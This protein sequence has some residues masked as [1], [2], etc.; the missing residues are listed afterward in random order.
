MCGGVWL[1]MQQCS[2]VG[3][4]IILSQDVEISTRFCILG[5]NV[6]VDGWSAVLNHPRILLAA[7]RFVYFRSSR[8]LD[9]SP[10]IDRASVGSNIAFCSPSLNTV[11][12]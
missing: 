9:F 8:L 6:S 5:A 7:L 11:D 12:T 3:L 2:W 4:P 10:C 1:V